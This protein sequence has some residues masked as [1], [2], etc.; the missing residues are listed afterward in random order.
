MTG[1]P[2]ERIREPGV[3][4]GIKDDSYDGPIDGFQTPTSVGIPG[5]KTYG[6]SGGHEYSVLFYPKATGKLRVGVGFPIDGGKHT[7]SITIRLRSPAA[8][9]QVH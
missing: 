1:N 8:G 4:V 7:G 6:Y 5:P 2:P 9:D 3:G